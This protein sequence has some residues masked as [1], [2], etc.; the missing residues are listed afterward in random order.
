MRRIYRTCAAAFMAGALGLAAAWAGVGLAP[1]PVPKAASPHPAASA[2]A[3]TP[4]RQVS[5][6]PG[7]ETS[8]VQVQSVLHSDVAAPSSQLPPGEF[9]VG[10]NRTSLAPAPELYGGTRWQT[11]GCFEVDKANPDTTHALP[12]PGHGWPASSPDCIYLGGFGLGPARAA[13]AVDDGGVWVRSLAV[14]NGT[15]TIVHQVIDSVGWFY[16]YQGSACAD[17]GWHDIRNAVSAQT[18]VPQDNLV[19]TST[20]SHSGP[21]NYGGWGGVPDWYWRQLRDSAI[22]SAKQAVANLVPGSLDTGSTVLRGMNGER[23]DHY[24]ST[25]DYQA[26]WLQL[27]EKDTGA[28][29]A[30]MANYAGHPTI[31]NTN[32]TATA[33]W[34]AAAGKC[35]FVGGPGTPLLHADWPGA[36][37]RSLEGRFGGVGLLIE[38]GL[39]NVSISRKPAGRPCDATADNPTGATFGKEDA[40]AE[41]T[42]AA[43]AASIAADVSK[44]PIPVTSNEIKVSVQQV[45]HPVMT[46]QGLAVLGSL[47]LFSREF[48]P[49]TPGADGPGAYRWTK[50]RNAGPGQLRGCETSSATQIKTV[51]GAHSI[52]EFGVAFAPGELF[53]NVTEVVKS[54]ASRNAALAVYSQAND[55]LGYLIQSFE[56]DYK[57]AGTA[58]EYATQTGEYEEAFALDHC[59]GDHVTQ[60]MID[61]A[62]AVGL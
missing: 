37:A 52:G 23:R 18:G 4:G 33:K 44:N 59:L 20:H 47:G 51:V 19:M 10:A 38:G 14:S 5:V 22:A 6:R 53:S 43:F 25:P 36:A 50:E 42:G 45:T 9:L 26:V 8:P 41:E 55:A 11:E 54:K 35:A 56:Y 39:G 40:E 21:D 28:A 57:G 17:C 16:R 7:A 15:Q 1:V 32:P 13:R 3:Q 34:D 30:T 62:R 49:G 61:A 46:N 29:V 2:A 60:S 48:V 24:Y 12:A 27:K 31:V 58:G